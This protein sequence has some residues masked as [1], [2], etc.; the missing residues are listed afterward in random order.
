MIL[1]E[2]ACVHM[3]ACVRVCVSVNEYACLYVLRMD[4]CVNVRVDVRIWVC[5]CVCLLV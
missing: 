4:V 1:R 2:C 5:V 3:G